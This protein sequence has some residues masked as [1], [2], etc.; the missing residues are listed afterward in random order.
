M[1]DNIIKEANGHSVVNSD[2]Q[3]DCGLEQ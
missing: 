3:I 1:H 2:V